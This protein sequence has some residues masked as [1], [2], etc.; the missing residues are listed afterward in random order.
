MLLDSIKKNIE[1]PC[2]RNCCLDESDVCV[3]CFR[4]LDEI[5]EWSKVSENDKQMILLK[6]Q[7]RRK[8]SQDSADAFV[9]IPSSF[10]NVKT[11]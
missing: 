8:I 10:I 4:S 1:S 6:T 3:G 11:L 9:S 5:L 2:I 7:T